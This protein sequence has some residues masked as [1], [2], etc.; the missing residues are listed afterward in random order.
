MCRKSFFF[1][2]RFGEDLGKGRVIAK[3]SARLFCISMENSGAS[4]RSNFIQFLSR[5]L[6]TRYVNK[7]WV[8]QFMVDSYR[9]VICERSIF[10]EADYENNESHCDNPAV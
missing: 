1:P 8:H 2:Y 6:V 9:Y 3:F 7:R 10:I 4:C 5:L